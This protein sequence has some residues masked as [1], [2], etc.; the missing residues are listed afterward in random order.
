[1]YS[2]GE[3]RKRVEDH[4]KIQ[5][6]AT[7]AFGDSIVEDF[8]QT[9]DRWLEDPVLYSNEYVRRYYNVFSGITNFDNDRA[10]LILDKSINWV[11]WPIGYELNISKIENGIEVKITW[12]V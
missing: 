12:D 9:L 1:M 3:L 6:K 11:L 7:M 2:V 5:D 10:V 4:F 8:K